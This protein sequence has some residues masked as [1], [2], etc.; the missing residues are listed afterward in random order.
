MDIQTKITNKIEEIRN[1]PENIRLRYVWGSVAICMI[2]I[3]IIWIF[4]AITMFDNSSNKNP[5]ITPI[6]DQLKNF[7]VE[8]PSIQNIP[9]Q[10]PTDNISNTYRT[11]DSAQQQTTQSNS[12]QSGV[13]NQ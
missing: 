5:D 8:M 6:K 12:N 7:K 13:I 3:I 11:N 4:S 2:F 1:K 10:E 9:Q